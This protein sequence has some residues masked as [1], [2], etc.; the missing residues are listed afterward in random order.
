MRLIVCRS[1][2]NSLGRRQGHEPNW[3]KAKDGPSVSDSAE[4]FGNDYFFT[5][6]PLSLNFWPKGLR[7][8]PPAGFLWHCPQGSPV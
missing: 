1:P 3:R 7:S 4:Y 8:P 5:L 2:N 6:K